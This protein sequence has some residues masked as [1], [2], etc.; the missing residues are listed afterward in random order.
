MT[1]RAT[2]PLIAERFAQLTCILV[3]QRR[4]GLILNTDITHHSRFEAPRKGREDNELTNLKPAVSAADR[5]EKVYWGLRARPSG[6]GSLPGR[7]RAKT[8][9]SIL[10]DEIPSKPRLADQSDTNQL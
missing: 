9:D 6:S 8:Q 4:F 10:G 2:P 1:L 5:N 3:Q 7:V